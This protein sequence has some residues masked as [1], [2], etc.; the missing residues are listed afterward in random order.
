MG[1]VMTQST[2][3]QKPADSKFSLET[4][5]NLAGTTITAPGIKLRY[6]VSETMAIRLGFDYSSYKDTYNPSDSVSSGTWV[7]CRC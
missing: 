6:F 4:E 1:V 5:L 7:D 2:F 3:A